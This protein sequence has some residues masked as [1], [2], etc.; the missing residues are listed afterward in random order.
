MRCAHK[1]QCPTADRKGSG[2]WVG[3]GVGTCKYN[4]TALNGNKYRQILLF[5][6]INKNGYHSHGGGGV[7]PVYT[8][9]CG[10]D[11]QPSLFRPPAL[12]K[13]IQTGRCSLPAKSLWAHMSGLSPR[14]IHVSLFTSPA[15]ASHGCTEW[16]PSPDTAASGS[17][18]S[19]DCSTCCCSSSC[20]I[21]RSIY[22]TA[23]RRHGS[24]QIFFTATSLDLE[25]YL[26]CNRYSVNVSEWMDEWAGSIWK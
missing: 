1:E 11:P 24:L 21:T 6:L 10:K 3:L 26:A 5:S 8:S 2:G 14:I 9:H 4:L 19:H 15:S 18:D 23:P 13:N 20:S 25:N 17:L 22:Y 7:S 16:A 12:I